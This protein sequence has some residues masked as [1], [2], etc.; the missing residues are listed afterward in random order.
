MARAQTDKN[1]QAKTKTT[2]TRLLQKAKQ[3]KDWTTYRQYQKLC[4][5]ACRQA[6]W[7]F[8]YI[9]NKIN[10]GLQNNTT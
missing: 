6:E 1:A 2:T 7:I 10:E 4:K 8:I 3:T 9:N 5:Q